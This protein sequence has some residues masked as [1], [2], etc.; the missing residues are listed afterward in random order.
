[1]GFGILTWLRKIFA[2]P[3]VLVVVL[4]MHRSG[5]SAVTEALAATDLPLNLGAHLLGAKPQ[6]P[7]GF[8]EDKRV[9]KA[10]QEFF[11]THGVHVMEPWR[12]PADFTMVGTDRM[13]IVFE[14]LMRENINLIKDPR[15]CVT[16]P[17]W[18][19]VWESK[20][21]PVY[22]HI[23]RHPAEV[24]LSLQK[25][26]GLSIEQGERVWLTHVLAA[27]R[28]SDLRSSVFMMHSD[29]LDHPEAEL[30]RVATELSGLT[31]FKFKEIRELT[32]DPTLI[33]ATT[34]GE[35][36]SPDVAAVWQKLVEF[37]QTRESNL[38][39]SLISGR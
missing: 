16:L 2:R 12:L 38:L 7:H 8:F 39:T 6:N 27:L 31:R 19:K 37:Q 9:I 23:W 28:N 15:L 11:E 14:K 25:R 18:Q 1:M 13:Q 32:I 35:I 36:L 4:G 34:P 26:D 3:P 21:K 24:A 17:Q 10:N 20:V 30:R 33:T 29:L 5:T 22:L